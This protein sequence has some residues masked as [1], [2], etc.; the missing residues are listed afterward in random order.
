MMRNSEDLCQ[1]SIGTPYFISP[2]ICSK[3]P[4][5]HKSDIWSLGCILFEILSLRHAFDAKSIVIYL[6]TI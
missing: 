4:Y 2:E 3:I 6:N 5:D 1:T